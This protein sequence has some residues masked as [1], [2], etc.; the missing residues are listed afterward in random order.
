MVAQCVGA[1][2]IKADRLLLGRRARH[3]RSYPDRWDI[4]RGSGPERNA[5]G[6]ADPK[7]THDTDQCANA[8]CPLFLRQ[9]VA[10]TLSVLPST[11]IFSA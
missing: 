1:I 10:Q 7:K 3:R 2:L 8:H 5:R 6:L 4:I 9:I 11:L